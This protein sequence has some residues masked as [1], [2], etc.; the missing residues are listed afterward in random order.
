MSCYF[1]QKVVIFEEIEF[2]K[3]KIHVG[4]RKLERRGK[5]QTKMKAE[6]Y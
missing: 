3:G 6:K 1:F 4:G 2:E 5:K